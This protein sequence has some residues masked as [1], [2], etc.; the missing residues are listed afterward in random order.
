MSQKSNKEAD[1]TNCD[2]LGKNK[3]NINAIKIENEKA[4][5]S[6][7]KSNSIISQSSDQKEKQ[8]NNNPNNTDPQKVV[9]DLGKKS[10]IKSEKS[11]DYEIQ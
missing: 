8:N 11:Q 7:I 10:E 4:K 3:S 6:L 2:I 5:I 9:I 1:S